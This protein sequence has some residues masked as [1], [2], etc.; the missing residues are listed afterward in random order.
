M[1][2][3]ETFLVKSAIQ[4]QIIMENFFKKETSVFDLSWFT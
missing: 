1:L 2:Q 3:N 4:K